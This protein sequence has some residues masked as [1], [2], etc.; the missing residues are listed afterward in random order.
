MVKIQNLIK[1]YKEFHLEC[2]MEVLPGRVIGLVGQNGAGKSTLFKSI[3]GLISTDGGSIEIM[4]KDSHDFCGQDKQKLGVVMADSGFSEWF[5]IKD[6]I[7]ILNSFYDSFDQEKF[8]ELCQRFQLPLN[9]Q[10]KEFS[11][12]MKA[13]LKLIVA[14]THDAGLLILDE[15]TAGLDVI[16]RSECFEILREFMERRE[17]NSILI[18]SHISADLEGL[19]DELYMIHQGQII[20]HEDT[21]MLL[22]EYGILK[23]DKEQYRKLDRSYIL[24]EK[25]E[26]YG[27]KCLTDKRKFYLEN[28]PEIAIEKGNIDE[29]I[30]MMILGK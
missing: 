16:A 21:D 4:G 8:L 20:F 12:G 7:P 26:T 3:L 30:V 23:V 15:P 9:K 29:L 22:G 13:K 18:S 28:Y 25:E 24:K 11:T 27:Y 6:I 17:D 19:C 14:T 5:K 2:S 1:N 10:I